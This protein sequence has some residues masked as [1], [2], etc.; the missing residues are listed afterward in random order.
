MPKGRLRTPLKRFRLFQKRE[1]RQNASTGQGYTTAFD[2]TSHDI[3]RECRDEHDNK[4]GK[5][6]PVEK[7]L[8]GLAA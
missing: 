8:T 1:Q 3:Y 2:Q 5:R 4:R 6:E 7:I